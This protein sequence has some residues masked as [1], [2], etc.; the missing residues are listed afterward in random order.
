MVG[1]HIDSKGSKAQPIFGVE[2]FDKS[3]DLNTLK[4][5]F[6]FQETKAYQYNAKTGTA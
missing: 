4:T 5:F 2:N 3:Y 6:C 1:T